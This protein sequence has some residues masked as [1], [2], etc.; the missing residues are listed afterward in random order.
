MRKISDVE[1]WGNMSWAG[2]RGKVGLEKFKNV[3]NMIY[4]NF[5][6]IVQLILYPRP[7]GFF[8]KAEKKKY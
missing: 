8:L 5:L 2:Q 1:F 3:V 7:K 4:G 6:Q